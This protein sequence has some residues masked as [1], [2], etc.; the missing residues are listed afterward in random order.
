[1]M[2]EALPFAMLNQELHLFSCLF[3]VAFVDEQQQ[4][5]TILQLLTNGPPNA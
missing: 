2:T 4:K 3:K 5:T 1:M